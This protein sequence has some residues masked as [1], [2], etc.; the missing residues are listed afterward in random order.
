MYGTLDNIPGVRSS[1]RTIY[2]YNPGILLY[3]MTYGYWPYDQ[4]NMDISFQI[5]SKML[6]LEPL[7]SFTILKGWYG[8]EYYSG[9]YTDS[10]VLLYIPRQEDPVPFIDGEEYLYAQ[11]SGRMGQSRLGANLVFGNVFQIGVGVWWQKQKI[12]LYKSLA[13]NRYWYSRGFSYPGVDAYFTSDHDVYVD[14]PVVQL[15]Y[16]NRVIFPLVFRYT[17]GHITSHITFILQKP[18]QLLIGTGFYF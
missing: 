13:F 2:T 14:K 16:Y 15:I 8:V 17:P 3:D 7:W 4:L 9:K 6:A 5:G 10:D 12:E 1:W 18:Q 11:G